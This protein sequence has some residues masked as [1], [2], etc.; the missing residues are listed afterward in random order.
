MKKILTITFIVVTFTL[1]ASMPRIANTQSASEIMKKYVDYF[2]VADETIQAKMTLINKQGKKRERELTIMT[3]EFTAD[4]DKILI[5]FT[6]PRSIYGAGLLI[7]ENEK[8][9]DD[10]WLYLP[11]L[12]KIKRISTSERSHSFMGSEFAYEDM[13]GEVT[14]DFNYTLAGSE[15]VNGKDCYIIEAKPVSARK[16][17]ETGYSKR[18]LWIRKDINFKVKVEYYD[19]KG[20]LLKTEYDEE[21]ITIPGGKLRMNLVTMV[22]N[23]SGNKTVLRSKHRMINS[24]VPG[25]KFTTTYLEHG[26]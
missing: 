15:N 23:R 18:R 16:I 25:T 5:R 9:S 7:E 6:K 2:D 20:E 4:L 17:E 11:V 21:L 14:D 3:K 8:R 12:K 24:G 13:H 10:Q 1:V 19:K 22:D 26:I